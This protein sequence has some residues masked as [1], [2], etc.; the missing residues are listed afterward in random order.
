MILNN[1]QYGVIILYSGYYNPIIVRIITEC[2]DIE[3]NQ[4]QVSGHI[5]QIGL[6]VA[7]A[8]ADARPFM[9]ITFR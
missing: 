5:F 7:V 8:Q 9:P 3:S 4:C 1:V 2:S 6:R